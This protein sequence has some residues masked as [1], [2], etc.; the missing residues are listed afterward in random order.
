MFSHIVLF[1]SFLFFSLLN[2]YFLWNFQFDKQKCRTKTWGLSKLSAHPRQMHRIQY[3]TQKAELYCIKL[4]R[5]KG[6]KSFCHFII[7]FIFSVY[8]LTSFFEFVHCLLIH[9]N[10]YCLLVS[11]NV[12]P[13]TYLFTSH[14]Y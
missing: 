1:F 5:E 8:S 9:V 14:H 4:K 10:C 2:L 13:F 11:A 6:E 7:R 3:I 12:S